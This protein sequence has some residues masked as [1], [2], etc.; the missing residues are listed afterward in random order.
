MSFCVTSLGIH[1]CMHNILW[2]IEVALLVISTLPSKSTNLYQWK[3]ILQAVYSH[4]NNN[5]IML[6]SAKLFSQDWASHE[7]R[8]CKRSKSTGSKSTCQQT[9]KAVFMKKGKIDP[10]RQRACRRLYP[11]NLNA[12]FDRNTVKKHI[13]WESWVHPLKSELKK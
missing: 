1:I 12:I 10:Y 6:F 11:L 5:S 13:C 9:L 7:R 8:P 3:R 2:C 4:G